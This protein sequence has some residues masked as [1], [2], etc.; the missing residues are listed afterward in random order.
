[1]KHLKCLKELSKAAGYRIH[2]VGTFS[3]ISSNSVEEGNVDSYFIYT[4][5]LTLVLAP[6][7]RCENW[8][9][10]LTLPKSDNFK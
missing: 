2:R 7:G 6:F 10:R 5:T 1:M 3:V 8:R 9:Q 4:A